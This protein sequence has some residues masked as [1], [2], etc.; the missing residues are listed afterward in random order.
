MSIS[1]NKVL[2][3]IIILAILQAVE[4][5]F[6]QPFIIGRNL[7][8]HPLFIMMLMMVAG[9]L[10]GLKGVFFAIPVFLVIRTISRYISDLKH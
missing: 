4:G 9:T 1:W 7:D 2:L 5:N 3:V 10:F 6:L 8:I